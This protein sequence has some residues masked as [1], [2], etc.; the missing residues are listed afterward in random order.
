MNPASTTTPAPGRI[1]ALV[2]VFLAPLLA[3]V[4]PGA[5]RLS[6]LFV[7]PIEMCVW[8]GGALLIREAARRWGLGWRNV[9]CLALALS[10]A[11]ECI[12]QQTSLAPMV[13]QIKGQVYAR[14]FGVNYVYFLWA[15]AYETVFVVFLPIQLAELIFPRWRGEPWLGRVGL[16]VTPVLFLA[17][18]FLA[19]FS[20]TQIARTKVFHQP[21]FNPPLLAVAAASV[22]IIGLVFTAVGPYRAWVARASSPLPPPAPRTL[23][24]AGGLWAVPLYGLVLLG[25]GLAP[26]F[27]PALAVAGGGALVAAALFTVPRWSAHPAWDQRH[28][29]GIVFGTLLGAMLVSFVGF[30]GAAR[31]DLYFKI[32][33]DVAAVGFFLV[34]GRRFRPASAT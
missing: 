26:A 27:P 30:I 16:I 25:F 22:A 29:F 20:W 11:E 2:L 10:V 5:T 32:I 17:G 9:L 15:L 33:A 6:S 8:G 7:F 13:I 18:S 21:A 3:E 19:W 23:G 34:L 4:L 31:M 24:V 12:I 14:A 28:G 1:P